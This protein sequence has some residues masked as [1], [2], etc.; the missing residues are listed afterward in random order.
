MRFLVIVILGGGSDVDVAII[1]ASSAN[2][3]GLSE[4]KKSFIFFYFADYVA[5]RLRTV[6][7]F[8]SESA[9]A[10]SEPRVAGPN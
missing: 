3:I 4:R 1:T 9:G 10:A 8:G 6:G 5:L 2:I 7:L